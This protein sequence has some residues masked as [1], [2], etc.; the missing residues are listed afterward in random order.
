MSGKQKLAF[1]LRK[2]TK[3][4]VKLPK[5]AKIKGKISTQRHDIHVYVYTMNKEIFIISCISKTRVFTSARIL[6]LEKLC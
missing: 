1:N 3:N 4:V 2:V 5:P 6:T